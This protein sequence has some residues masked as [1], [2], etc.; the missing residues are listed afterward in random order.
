MTGFQL[1][2]LQKYR[3]ILYRTQHVFF[4]ISSSVDTQT[5]TNLFFL[6]LFSY[7]MKIPRSLLPSVGAQNLYLILYSVLLMDLHLPVTPETFV[8]AFKFL[9]EAS[10]YARSLPPPA[11]IT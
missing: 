1:V 6:C 10:I 8:S 7:S 2:F 3:L 4:L 11:A 5:Y 9:S